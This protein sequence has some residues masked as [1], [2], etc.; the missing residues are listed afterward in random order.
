MKPG[1]SFRLYANPVKLGFF[2]VASIGFTG[3]AYQSLFQSKAPMDGWDGFIAWTGLILFGLGIFIFSAMF[4]L[5][6]IAR[7]PLLEITPER[8][9]IQPFIAPWNVTYLPWSDV[10]SIGVYWEV[11]QRTR[12]YW[13]ALTTNTYYRTR[14]ILF[15]RWQSRIFLAQ[16]IFDRQ[17]LNIIFLWTSPARCE[18]LLADIQTTCANEIARYDVIVEQSIQRLR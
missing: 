16:S 7:R 9:R 10:A 18:R 12:R 8:W 1:Y 15:W 4:L 6:I 11:G 3:F 17:L 2:L 13:L 14:Q 5:F